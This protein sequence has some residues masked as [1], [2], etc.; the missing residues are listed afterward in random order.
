M[1]SERNGTLYVGVT[2]NLVARVWQHRNHVVE[3]FTDR[4]DIGMLVWYELHGTMESAILR[5]KQIKKW[6][7]AWK[8]R[9]IQ[10]GNPQWLDLWDSIVG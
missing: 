3:G 7:R 10:E 4:Y 5:E 6:N 9:L 8:L 2:S 1:A